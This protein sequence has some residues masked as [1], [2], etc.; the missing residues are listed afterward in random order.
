MNDNSQNSLGLLNKLLALSGND[1][2]KWQNASLG[3]GFSLNL[4]ESGNL[5][6]MQWKSSET[7]PESY[8]LAV[9]GPQSE[10]KANIKAEEGDQSNL[11]VFSKL[12]DLFQKASQEAK[13]TDSDSLNS[14]Q[15]LLDSMLVKS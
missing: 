2:P 9:F 15:S 4:G 6:L 5:F 1:V 12:G 3:T 10:V 7:K 8:V 14:I 13:A 11:E